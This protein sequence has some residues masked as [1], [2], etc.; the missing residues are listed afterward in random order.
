VTLTVEL[1]K[2]GLPLDHFVFKTI[3]RS[4]GVISPRVHV[5]NFDTYVFCKNNKP[6]SWYG[7]AYSKAFIGGKWQFAR[8][9]LSEKSVPIKCG[10]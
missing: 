8:H 3:T 9:V 4:P 5:E 1:W 6:T 7:V 2:A 10:T